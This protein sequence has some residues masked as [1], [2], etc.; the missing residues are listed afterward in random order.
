MFPEVLKRN[1]YATIALRFELQQRK[2]MSH[3]L[4][5]SVLGGCQLNREYT[6]P[7]GKKKRVDLGIQCAHTQEFSDEYTEGKSI[8]FP[9]WPLWVGSFQ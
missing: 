8:L 1:L 6:F 3:T 7:R 4:L 2:N 5:D 9:P